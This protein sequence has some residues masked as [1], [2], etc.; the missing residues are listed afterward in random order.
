MDLPG[1]LE[2]VLEGV[3]VIVEDPGMVWMSIAHDPAIFWG[4]ALVLAFSAVVLAYLVFR[5]PRK[6]VVRRYRFK[7]A[8]LAIEERR[9]I[10]TRG[11]PGYRYCS[12]R[13]RFGNN[14]VSSGND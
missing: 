9:E 8:T 10:L 11:D 5:K 4:V 3:M 1:Y 7:P 13:G 2:N 12:D 6:V 14:S